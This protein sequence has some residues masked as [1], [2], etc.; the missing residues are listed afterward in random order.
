M[1]SGKSTFL[2]VFSKVPEFLLVAFTLLEILWAA[3]YFVVVV[4]VVFLV[5]FFFFCCV[6]HVFFFF[7]PKKITLVS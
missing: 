4:V 3:I 6:T 1:P 5:F 2:C 7:L